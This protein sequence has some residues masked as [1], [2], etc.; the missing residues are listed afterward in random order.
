[1]EYEAGDVI[2]YR[3]FG[4]GLRRVL[5]EERLADVKHGRPGFDGTVV[6]GPEK[7]TPVWGYDHQI[8]AQRL[9]RNE[10]RTRRRAASRAAGLPQEGTG[11][12]AGST[13]SGW[14][15]GRMSRWA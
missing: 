14:P 6:S 11:A 5:V 8:V 13:S 10:D 1:V 7:G 3:P 9:A 4:G 15:G 12:T 2:W